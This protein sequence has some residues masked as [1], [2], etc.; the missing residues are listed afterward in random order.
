M[1]GGGKNK[2]DPAAGLTVFL[3]GGAVR[4]EL[5]GLPAKERD[6]VVVNGDKKHM[7]DAGFIPVGHDFP[8]F[9]HPLSKEEYALARSEKKTAPGYH[10]FSFYTGKDVT[11]EEDLG[12]RD[13]TINAMARAQD[14]RLIDPWGG[15][16]DL[17]K[18]KLRHVS[19][20]FGEDPVRIVRTARFAAKLSHLGFAVAEETMKLMRAMVD[21]G[22]ADALA[23][24][25][26][27]LECTKAWREP[28]PSAFFQTLSTAGALKVLDPRLAR[29]FAD[30]NKSQIVAHAV[31]RAAQRH[32]GVVFPA[33]ALSCAYCKQ[34]LLPFCIKMKSP[35]AYRKTARHAETFMQTIRQNRRR[36][37]AVLDAL[38]KTDAFR[39][40]RQLTILLDALRFCDSFIRDAEGWIA[41]F[42]RALLRLKKVELRPIAE[43]CRHGDEIKAA[44][45][46]ARLKALG[47]L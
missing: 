10:G 32:N 24:E 19:D 13:L 18:K 7:L 41:S 35:A 2:R 12:R 23:P 4:D 43:Q 40:P 42:K 25:R 14:G 9:I 33:L 8:V 1:D 22:E 21:A 37:E 11:L 20:A 47:K 36:A 17:R 15:R 34:S 44:V 30:P 6:W 16:E 45:H 26:A 38:E 29:L 46:A 28:R 39:N 31:D 3:V 27:W 5:L